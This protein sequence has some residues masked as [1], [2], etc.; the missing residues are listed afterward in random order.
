MSATEQGVT[1]RVS[2][3]VADIRSEVVS[4]ER[5][6]AVALDDAHAVDPTVLDEL[7]ARVW[8]RVQKGRGG[9]WTWTGAVDAQGRGRF[10]VPGV[11]T[12]LARRVVW[13]LIHGAIPG[14]L[15]LRGTCGNQRCVCDRHAVLTTPRESTGDIAEEHDSGFWQD[16]ASFLEW[17]ADRGSSPKTLPTYRDSLGRFELWRAENAPEV[18]TL[19]DLGGPQVRDYARWLRT[20]RT[21]KGGLLGEA[22]RAKNLHVLRSLL[23][24][25]GRDLD[26][27]VISR[28]KVPV[29]RLGERVPRRVCQLDEAVRLIESIA[30]GTETGRRDRALLGVLFTSGLRVAELVALDRAQFPIAQLGTGDAFPFTVYRGKGKKARLAFLNRSAQDLLAE[31]LADRRDAQPALFVHRR[32]GRKVDPDWRLT[33]RTVQSLLARQCAALGLDSVTPHSLRHGFATL[34]LMKTGDL[35]TVQTLLGHASI[36]TTQIYTHI[37]D[38]RLAQQYAGIFADVALAEEGDSA[39]TTDRRP[40][41]AGVRD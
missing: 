32:P 12:I 23:K 13:T 27:D 16:C 9:C 8:T 25:A 41:L 34:S 4:A 15:E 26:I 17:L 38:P 6:P 21:R 28:D 11:G 18:E 31:S 10:N 33:V 40:G 30:P 1:V 14:N 39:E 24:W 5:R 37:S 2:D 7:A 20:I 19:T 3:L 22:T 36:T 29:P 35:R